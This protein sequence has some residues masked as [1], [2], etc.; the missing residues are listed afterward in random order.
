MSEARLMVRMQR[1]G[2][3]VPALYDLDPGAGIM[4]MQRMPGR[5]LIDVL[6]DDALPTSF[7]QNALTSTGAAIRNVHRLAIT[8][9]PFHQQRADQRRGARDAH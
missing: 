3:A 9:R 5:A 1:A 8:W 4:V 7:K 6:R 2:I